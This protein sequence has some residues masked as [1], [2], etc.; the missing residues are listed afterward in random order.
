MSKRV[1]LTFA[2]LGLL[3]CQR[4]DRKKVIAVIP[5]ATS[6]VFWVT[7][8]TGAKAAEKQ[9][10]VQVDWSGPAQETDFA[11]QVQIVD[12]MVSRRVD[13]IALAA[14]ERTALSPP[15]ERAAAAGI[16]LVVFDSGVDT[17]QYV[18]FIATN[19]Y[20][21]GVLGARTLA[22]LI[23]GKGN[24]GLI[25]HAPGSNSTMDREKGFEETI[26]KEFPNIKI[27]GRQYSMSDR[28][29]GRAATEN[30]LTANANLDG[31]FCSAEPGSVGA[32]LAVKARNL[33]GKVK[34]VTFDASEGLV[35]DLKG[36]TIDAM[37]VQD[38]Y[39][40]GFEAVQTLVN[41]LNGKAVQKRVD[42]SP[43]VVTKPDLDRPEVQRLLFPKVQ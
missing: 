22:R 36:G 42:L 5:K 34:L 6:H 7:V 41:K 26:A 27:V 38:P 31:I 23:N 40:M 3:S 13:G 2:V 24:V 25:Q 17:E 37:V 30:I 16:P 28:A 10:N 1:L 12:S 33:S 43:Q 21:G 29:K 15:V 18:S 32:A 39:R 20:E 14:G 4:Q 19:N 35:E 9:F 8:E 11:R